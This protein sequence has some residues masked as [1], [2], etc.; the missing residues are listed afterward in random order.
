M[1][2]SELLLGDGVESTEARLYLVPDSKRGV[3][4]VGG[5][6]G[7]WDTPA[8]ALY[9]KLGMELTH[10]GI[11]V[12]R[13]RYR[14]PHDLTGS[15]H[16]SVAGCNYLQGLGISTLGLV[17]HSM[18]GAVVIQSALRNEAVRAVVALST[19]TYGAQAVDKLGD[20]CAILLIHGRNDSVLPPT[21]SKHV[22]SLAH[23][24]RKLVI[25]NGAD[26]SLDSVS[27]MVKS[28]VL[29]WFSHY[30]RAKTA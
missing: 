14:D 26:H 17:G 22:H 20:R 7:D 27:D 6:G 30:L 25:Y 13:V 12:M 9:P 15:V 28:E 2:Y 19:Q 1:K 11:T 23:E 5:I 10:T 29:Q 24:P 4:L 18:G 8:D 3:I 16:D 21:C